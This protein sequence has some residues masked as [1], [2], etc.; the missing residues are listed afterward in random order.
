MTVPDILPYH[1]DCYVEIDDVQDAATK[2]FI[3]DA[4]ITVTL[5][6]KSGDPIA[7]AEDLQATYVPGT[8]A[9]YRALIPRTADVKLNQKLKCKATATKGALEVVFVQDVIVKELDA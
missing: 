7:N 6:T 9:L 5:Y 3:I 4:Q 8:D 1:S 2:D